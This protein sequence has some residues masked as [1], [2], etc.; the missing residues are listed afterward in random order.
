MCLSKE[1]QEIL[2]KIDKLR[3]ITGNK[4]LKF[5]EVELEKDFGPVEYD[6]M[7]QVS[8]NLLG[9]PSRKG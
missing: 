1:K 4:D 6:R 5:D 7:M 2:D 3:N 9:L 8:G